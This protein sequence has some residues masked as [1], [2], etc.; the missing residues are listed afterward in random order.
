[1]IDPSRRNIG[2]LNHEEI[3]YV[4]IRNQHVGFSAGKPP[5]ISWAEHPVAWQVTPF[6]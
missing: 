2:H 1:M 6:Q 4:S 5:T 3:Q